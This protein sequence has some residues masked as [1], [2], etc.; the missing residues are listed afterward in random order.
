MTM[1]P[2]ESTRLSCHG[3]FA[4]LSM[5]FTAAFCMEAIFEMA[6]NLNDLLATI[7]LI[8]VTARRC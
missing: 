5:T 1:T 8:F 6:S 7:E 4:T 2:L 3:C